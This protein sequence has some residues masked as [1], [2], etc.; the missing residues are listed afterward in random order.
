MQGSRAV[1]QLLLAHGADPSAVDEV[2]SVRLGLQAEI[3]CVIFTTWIVRLI[4]RISW[5]E[6]QHSAAA[7]QQV[8]PHGRRRHAAGTA[9]TAGQCLLSFYIYINHW[10]VVS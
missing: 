7:G 9:A 3:L 5:A 8:R 2:C 1:I 6:R 10:L 4:H